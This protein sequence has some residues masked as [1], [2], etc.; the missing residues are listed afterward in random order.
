MHFRRWA[1][2]GLL[3]GLVLAGCSSSGV[4]SQSTT[5]SSGITPAFA[6]AFITKMMETN[7]KANKAL[8][9]SLLA[10]YESGSAFNLDNA[11]NDQERL[12]LKAKDPL[13]AY[14]PFDLDVR[15]V[16]VV[17]RPSGEESFVVIGT[18]HTLVQNPPK[19]PACDSVLD[20]ERP[21][22][23]ASFKL[24]LEPS[25]PPSD[26]PPLA[27]SADGYE[28][29]VSS[30]Q[31][32]M[33]AKLPQR[34]V[35]AFLTEE[36]SGKLGPFAKSSFTRAC[37]SL[38]DPRLD[39]VDAESKDD[40][41]RDLYS[42]AQPPDVSEYALTSGRTLVMFTLRFDDEVVAPSSSPIEW[43]HTATAKD[44]AE[45]SVYLLKAGAYKEVSEAGEIEIAAVVQ[46][47]G[48][49]AVVGSYPGVT[50]ITGVVA[51]PT[52]TPGTG[53]LTAQLS[54]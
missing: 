5:S 29:P 46:P 27:I 8:S 39:V 6:R 4:A 40:D 24:A 10:T 54:G 22:S 16:G 17:R 26:L 7:N 18:P 12:A 15:S 25:V 23:S 53:T 35:T 52:S 28:A 38:P 49:Y 36:T 34:V 13:A 45:P 14:T 11:T 48:A 31:Q 2:L 32:S 30:S 3:A 9:S 51:S 50:G 20:L 41:A 47:S 43:T 1:G 42:V 33:A 37:G 21:S 44:P 19:L